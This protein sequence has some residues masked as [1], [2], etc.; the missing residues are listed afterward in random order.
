MPSTTRSLLRIGWIAARLPAPPTCHLM[1]FAS[2]R[3][4]GADVLVRALP[5]FIG[6]PYYVDKVLKCANSSEIPSAQPT[7]F[8]LVIKRNTANALGL[9]W[10]TTLLAQADEVIE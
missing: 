9:T 8:E 2:S 7:K 10:P 3:R 5:T 4:T 1:A 6:A